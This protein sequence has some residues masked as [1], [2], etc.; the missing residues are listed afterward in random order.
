VDI[1]S[2]D[3]V[4]NKQD[5]NTYSHA[6]TVFLARVRN[7]AHPYSRILVIGRKGTPD[8]ALSTLPHDYETEQKRIRLFDATRSAVYA[9]GDTNTFFVLVTLTA[10]KDVTISYLRAICPHFLPLPG[11][12]EKAG[13]LSEKQKRLMKIQLV[14]KNITEANSNRRV[15]DIG[16]GVLVLGLALGGLWLARNTIIRALAVVFRGHVWGY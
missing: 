7:Q 13:S 12:L 11:E 3:I 10:D 5:P 4:M 15:L 9:V 16:M 14:C 1:G 8:S 6:L 2:L